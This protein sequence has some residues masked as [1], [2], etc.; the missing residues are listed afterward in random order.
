MV[1]KV[2][3]QVQISKDQDFFYPTT[4]KTFPTPYQQTTL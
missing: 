3:N 2:E 1:G 4:S